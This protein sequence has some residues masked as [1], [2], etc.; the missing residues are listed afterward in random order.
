MH[1]MA[2]ISSMM[3]EKGRTIILVI[4]RRVRMNSIWSGFDFI[5]FFLCRCQ[6]GKYATALSLPTL[7]PFTMTHHITPT[8]IEP[9]FER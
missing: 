6:H 4:Q 9:L 8:P 1:F 5:P 7:V 3:M 2:K